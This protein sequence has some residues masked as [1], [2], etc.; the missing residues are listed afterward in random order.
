M[1]DH[2]KSVNQLSIEH[3]IELDQ[4]R[5]LVTIE[6]VFERAVAA[7]LGFERVE[8]V[9]DNLVERHIVV[10]L[11]A[12]RCD[13]FHVQHRAAPLL[14]QLHDAADIIVRNHDVRLDHRFLNMVDLLR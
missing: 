1:H 9:I 5:F 13:V 4:L 10:Q 2:R 8:K 11:Y 3:D 7:R 14:A 12:R 6:F